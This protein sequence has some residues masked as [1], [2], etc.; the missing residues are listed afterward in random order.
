G[1]VGPDTAAVL[2][3]I[4]QGE[5]GVRPGAAEYFR[6]VRRLCDE[7]GALLIVDEV[8]TGFG[9]T[10][11]WFACEHVGVTPDLICLG[12]AIAG[13]VPMGA[14]AIGARVGELPTGSHGSTFGGNPLACAAALAALDAYKQ[15]ALIER[16]AE[17]GEYLLSRLRTI[18]SP[19]IREVRGLGLMVGVELKV[20]VTPLLQ[21]LM[22]GGILAL[23]AGS[24]VLRLLPPLVIT[25]QEV[26]RVLDGLTEVLAELVRPVVEEQVV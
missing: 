16:A 9:R 14:V 11:R 10:G 13:G 4:V 18:E 8:Q 21:L 22:D 24:T 5:G 3:E 7:R 25:R 23:P 1:A 26:D 2:V 6:G 17:T 12:K 15:E 20:R 19:L